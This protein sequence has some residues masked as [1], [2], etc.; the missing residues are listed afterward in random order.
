MGELPPQV[1]NIV[2]QLQ[3]LQ[4]QLQL[5]VTQKAQVEALIKETQD[6][7]SELEKSK[8]DFAY[9]A[10]GNVMVKLEKSEVIKD[11]KEKLETYEVR[12]SML[13][14]QEN[15][16]RERLSDLQ[17]KLQAMLGGTQAG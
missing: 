3:Q 4:Q 12:K 6:A 10:V 16:L 15:K 9:K 2:A 1:Q 8:E 14:K 5:V 17:S 13:E 7:L 11:L